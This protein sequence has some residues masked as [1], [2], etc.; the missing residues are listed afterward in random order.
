MGYAHNKRKKNI[1][2]FIA[3]K[4]KLEFEFIRHMWKLVRS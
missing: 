3:G 1:K 2:R 4:G